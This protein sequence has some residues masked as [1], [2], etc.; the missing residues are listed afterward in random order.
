VRTTSNSHP[1]RT[2]E[3]TM[4]I[5]RTWL[6]LLAALAAIALAAVTERDP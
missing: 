2:P 3:A 5:K 6:V 1:G 4:R